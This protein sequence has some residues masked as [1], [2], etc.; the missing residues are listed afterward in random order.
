M[1][2]I[3]ILLLITIMANAVMDAIISNDSFAKHGLWFSRDGWKCKYLI[4]EWLNNFLPLELSSFLGETV[5]VV[6]SDLWHL[7]KTIMILSFMVLVFGFTWYAVIMYFAWGLIFSGF[8]Y[9][10]R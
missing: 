5:L 7:A 10:I 1:T 2:D 9:W 4:V 8:Y 3:Y 6:F